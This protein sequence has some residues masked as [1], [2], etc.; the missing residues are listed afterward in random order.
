MNI[1]ELIIAR[2]LL[3]VSSEPAYRES[4]DKLYSFVSDSP[5][6]KTLIDS[7]FAAILKNEAEPDVLGEFLASGGTYDEYD[8]ITENLNDII[9]TPSVLKGAITRE[10]NREKAGRIKEM[11]VDYEHDRIQI[12][13]LVASI[14]DEETEDRQSI[15]L[16][17]VI[18]QEKTSPTAVKLATHYRYTDSRLGGLQRG[19]MTVLAARPAVGKSDYALSVARNVMREGRN[20]FLASLEMDKFEILKRMKRA[21]LGVEPLINMK[22]QMEID[23]RGD[24]TV[25]QIAASVNIGNYDL[26]IVDHMQ[27]LIY[28]HRFSGLYERMT[29]LSNQ[30][31]I[32]AK[33]S[34]AA[35]LVL[36]QLSRQTKD[37]HKAP[38]LSDLRDS[39]AIEQDAYAVMFLHE[40]NDR[41]YTKDER[42]LDL[43]IAKNRGGAGGV[44]GYIFMPGQS[45]WR[46]N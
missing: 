37:E 39:G 17:E 9:L 1:N 43:T 13:D 23:E 29:M 41:D 44:I 2:A 26:V 31:R 35:W 24:L 34:R 36:S 14:I 3:F 19:R 46:E 27:L 12:E 33:H 40:P 16:M 45:R 21:E 5:A 8:K 25:P 4:L 11:I 42:S 7:R 20:V 6:L 15:S 18:R 38:K 22:G 32:A 30:L 10:S 28:P